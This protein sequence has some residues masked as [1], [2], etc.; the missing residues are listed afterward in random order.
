M[1]QSLTYIKL[2][3]FLRASMF[4]LLT[5]VRQNFFPE[6]ICISNENENSKNF[7]DYPLRRS[8]L[9]WLLNQT[10]PFKNISRF[11]IDFIYF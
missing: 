7:K 4:L 2:I 5:I 10:D 1:L 11:D 3:F 6:N 8:L 9:N